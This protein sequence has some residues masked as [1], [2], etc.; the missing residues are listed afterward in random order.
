MSARVD[1]EENETRALF[2]IVDVANKYFLEIGSGDGQLTWRY[3]AVGD[4]NLRVQ[5]RAW[6]KVVIGDPT[7]CL[8]SLEVFDEETGRTTVFIGDPND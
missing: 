3:A 5:I 4:P 7:L 2:G 8:S 6:I 1:P